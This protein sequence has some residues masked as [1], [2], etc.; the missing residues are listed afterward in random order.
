MSF[1]KRTMDYLGLG[2][3][4]AYDDYDVEEEYEP[5]PRGRR[6]DAEP[7]APRHRD[8]TGGEGVV[9]TLPSRPTFPSRDFDPSQA[10]RSGEH[11]D[12]S[13][14]QPRPQR[15]GR[16]AGTGSNEPAT[17]K[18]R[19]F[20]QAQEVADKFKE[21]N[22][23]I[24][25]LEGSDRE[26]ARRLID[27]ASG[28]CYGLDGSMEKVANGVYLLKPPVGRSTRPDEVDAFLAEVAKALESARQQAT[29]M[30]ARAR[31]AVAR[32]QEVTSAAETAPPPPAP[33]ERAVTDEATAADQRSIQLPQVEAETISRTLLL[34]QRTADTTV[35]EA[36][37]EAER[38]VRE[39]TVEAEST[40][41]STREMSAQMLEDA[42][43]EARRASQDARREAENEVESLVARRE[44]LIGDVD[45]L[46]RFLIDQRDRLRGAARQIEALCD[47]VPEGLGS[48]RP[49][50]LS[51]SDDDDPGDPTQE[52]L[53][54]NDASSDH[55]R[56]E[57][58]LDG[59][60]DRK[61]DDSDPSAL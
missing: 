39:A 30:E 27:F 26:V 53:R 25:N 40:I 42:R 1:W 21:G 7:R 5:A 51:A 33:P 61:S 19:R 31:A 45:Q 35:A 57:S 32:L 8:E 10:R 50:A 56:L 4:D 38:L 29:A 14:V 43:A 22:P 48:V 59:N 20:D 18:P 3:D 54:P 6:Q 46:E 47:R 49:P 13:G 16:P 34:A 55:G 23:V 37:S 11:R 60:G 17:V 58:V 36:R 44:F 28:L 15:N 2:P 41:D 52:L 9:R 24:M 12:D